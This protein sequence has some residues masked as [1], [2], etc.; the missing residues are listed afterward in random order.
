MAQKGKKAGSGKKGGGG[1]SVILGTKISEKYDSDREE[2]RAERTERKE[3]VPEK[4]AAPP[5]KPMKPASPGELRNKSREIE[6]MLASLEKARSTSEL[7]TYSYNR[8]KKKYEADLAKIKTL[9]EGMGGPTPAEEKGPSPGGMAKAGKTKAKA[10]GAA[11]EAP[12]SSKMDELAERV[13]KIESFHGMM[14]GFKSQLDLLKGKMNEYQQVV[15][16][17]KSDE[18]A[19]A[20]E[21]PRVKRSLSAMKG[22]ARRERAMKK[23]AAG[24]PPA[25]DVSGLEKISGKVDTLAGKLTETLEALKSRIDQVSVIDEAET[26]GYV[27]ALKTD[28]GKVRS[29]LAHFLKKDDLKKL[30]LQPVA[31]GGKGPV[32]APKKAKPRAKKMDI[33][34]IDDLDGHLGKDV[35][36]EC[37]LSML[38]SVTQSGMRMYWYRI[39][40][41]TG[42]SILI[43]SS[44]MKAQQGRD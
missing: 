7:P 41:G 5:P 29:E 11:P 3:P 42:E 37:S 31:E 23:A 24:E 38:K 1:F 36:V 26:K 30:V 27:R 17:L 15:D 34:A 2:E 25:P 8:L 4:P 43:S 10:E 44:E 14:P 6:K 9:L 35:T 16:R 19:L 28:I 12:G 20:I 21:L 33:I 39:E 32:P 13:E 22:R 18:Q 40:D